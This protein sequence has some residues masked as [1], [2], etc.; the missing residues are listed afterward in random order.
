MMYDLLP[1]IAV[2]FIA[3]TLALPFT[4]EDTRAGVDP[5]YTLYVLAAWFAYFGLCWTRAGQTLGLRAW[6]VEIVTDTGAR[7]GWG[8][9]AVRYGAAF[10]STAALG[11]GFW[12]SLLRE[13]RACWH[14]RLSG[15][16]LQRIG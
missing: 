1:A 12:S 2:V 9:A 10:L 5:L 13:D 3:A 16:R 15:T 8:A 14:D 4:P 11:L 7:P 6:R